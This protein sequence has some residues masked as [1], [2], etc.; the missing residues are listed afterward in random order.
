MQ[1]MKV[2][3]AAFV[4]AGVAGS[5]PAASAKKHHKSHS[6]SMKKGSM[7]GG[8]GMSGGGMSKGGTTGGGMSGGGM[9]PSQGSSQG[10]VGP[11]TT[12]N[13]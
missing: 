4:V 2:L 9:A 8:A 13:K 12:P 11:G 1:T 5:V 6:M 10:N 3:I 7:S